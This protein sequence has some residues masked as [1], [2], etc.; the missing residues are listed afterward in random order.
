MQIRERLLLSEMWCPPTSFSVAIRHHD[1]HRSLV[2]GTG[3]DFPNPAADYMAVVA[4]PT[5]V[6]DWDTDS[7]MVEETFAV[8]PSTGSYRN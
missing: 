4:G 2:A 8:P 3:W 7:H 1:C 6:A 5:F